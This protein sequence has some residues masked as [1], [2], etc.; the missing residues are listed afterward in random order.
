MAD[1]DLSKYTEIRF[2]IRCDGE[3][4]AEIGLVEN[5][6]FKALAF[7]NSD[8][9]EIK[10]VN[11]GNGKFQAYVNGTW[12]NFSLPTDANLSDLQIRLATSG[13]FYLSEVL[14]K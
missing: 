10:F 9:V 3:H 4:W 1:V 5:G 7:N 11:E 13:T 8:W 2:S 12:K 14:C 6:D